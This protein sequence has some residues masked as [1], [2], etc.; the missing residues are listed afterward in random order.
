MANIPRLRAFTYA[1]RI[2]EC[3]DTAISRG[4]YHIPK[5]TPYCYYKRVTKVIR[6]VK[7]NVLSYPWYTVLYTMAVSQSAFRA[8]TTQWLM[9]VRSLVSVYVQY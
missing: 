6:A 1:R 5:T 3:L 2:A 9:L 7:I 4:I 8:G